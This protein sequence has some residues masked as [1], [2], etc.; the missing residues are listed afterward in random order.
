MYITQVAEL[1]QVY[2]QMPAHGMTAGEP[3]ATCSRGVCAGRCRWVWSFNL[4]L[5]PTVPPGLI[6]SFLAIDRIALHL[7]VIIPN[8]VKLH[9]RR[10]RRWGSLCASGISS[11]ATC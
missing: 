5:F 10:T 3:Q 7:Y 1:S 6:P 4:P 9:L 2:E 11:S 8:R